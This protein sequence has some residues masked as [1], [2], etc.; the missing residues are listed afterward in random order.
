MKQEIVAMTKKHLQSLNAGREFMLKVKFVYVVLS[1]APEQ[2]N[3]FHAY[4]MRGFQKY[5][6]N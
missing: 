3:V 4:L 2:G 5:G 1:G 6:R